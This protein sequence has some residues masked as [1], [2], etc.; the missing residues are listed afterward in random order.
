MFP[1]LILDILWRIIYDPDS[2]EWG[3]GNCLYGGIEGSAENMGW[4]FST[5]IINVDVVF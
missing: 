2:E 1:G 3:E 5:Q 4:E